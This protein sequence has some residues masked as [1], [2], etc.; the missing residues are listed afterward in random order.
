[1][2]PEVA[3]MFSDF[4]HRAHPRGI[5]L[6]TIERTFLS[7][8]APIIALVTLLAIFFGVYLRLV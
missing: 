4:Q 7:T 1:M 2:K 6:N 8:S 3:L 5:F